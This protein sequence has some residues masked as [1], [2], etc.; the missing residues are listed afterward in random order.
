MNL[1]LSLILMNKM[2]SHQQKVNRAFANAKNMQ[3]RNPLSIVY[4]K[5]CGKTIK[6]YNK[7]I[8]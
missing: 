5:F 2:M 1:T 8:L 3:C 4:S 7:G 6:S